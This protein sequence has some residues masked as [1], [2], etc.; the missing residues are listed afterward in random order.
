MENDIGDITEMSLPKGV[1]TIVSSIYYHDKGILV[2]S[3]EEGVYYRHIDGDELVIV[4]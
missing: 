2:I 4:K 3:T 1:N